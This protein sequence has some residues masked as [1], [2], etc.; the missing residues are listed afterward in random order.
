MANDTTCVLWEGARNA[1]GYGVLPVARY[2]TRL[3]HRAALADTLG[4]PVEGVAMHTCDNPP[5]VNPEHLREGTQADNMR[6]CSEKGRARGHFSD[7]STCKY[8]HE[9]TPENTRTVHHSDGR[10]ERICRACRRRINK[11]IAARRKAQRALK[12]EKTNGQ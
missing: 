5:C 3:A 11:E 12:K 4:R 1:G 10:T 8:G 9:F 2:G 6:D 7:V